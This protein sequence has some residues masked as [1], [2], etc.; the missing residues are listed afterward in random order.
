MVWAAEGVAEQLNVSTVDARDD[1]T[2]RI[3]VVVSEVAGEL[4]CGSRIVMRQRHHSGEPEAITDVLKVMGEALVASDE[5][6]CDT[7]C[8]RVAHEFVLRNEMDVGEDRC[9]VH[10]VQ[11]EVLE[12]VEMLGIAVGPSP[13]GFIH[14]AVP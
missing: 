4:P 7:C 3:C 9:F 13:I 14:A 5:V 12:C 8:E 11:D 6:N 2:H 10:P 1:L